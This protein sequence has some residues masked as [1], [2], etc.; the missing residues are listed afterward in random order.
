MNYSSVVA[1]NV[2]IK[3]NVISGKSRFCVVNLNEIKT[4]SCSYDLSIMQEHPLLPVWCSKDRQMSGTPPI[5]NVCIT[6]NLSIHA[7][8]KNYKDSIQ[9]SVR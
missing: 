9:A 1:K 2:P 5:F 7:I 6:S 3:K 8:L 4:L